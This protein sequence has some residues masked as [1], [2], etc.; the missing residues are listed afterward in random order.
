MTTSPPGSTPGS[1]ELAVEM[2]AET[3]GS[4]R[5][6][7]K[8]APSK[9]DATAGLDSSDAPSGDPVQVTL[10]VPPYTRWAYWRVLTIGDGT[11]VATIEGSARTADDHGHQPARRIPLLGCQLDASSRHR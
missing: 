10:R 11:V 2:K 3:V 7:P 8:M 6:A 1:P 4:P 9:V 5:L